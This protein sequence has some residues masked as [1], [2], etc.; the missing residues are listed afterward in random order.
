MAISRSANT[1]KAPDR[2]NAKEDCHA[3]QDGYIDAGPW[4]RRATHT[5]RQVIELICR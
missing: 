4:S 5:H 3:R 2:Q 1:V